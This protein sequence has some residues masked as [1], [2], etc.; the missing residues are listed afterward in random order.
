MK[1]MITAR[2]VPLLQDSVNH[3]FRATPPFSQ[4]IRRFTNNVSDMKKL[5]ARDYEDMLQVTSLP[6]HDPQQTHCR[7]ITPYHNHPHRH[8]AVMRPTPHCPASS[9]LALSPPLTLSSPLAPHL[10]ISLRHHLAVPSH[11]ISPCPIAVRCWPYPPPMD[12]CSIPVF[13]DLLDGH[14]NK[15]LIKLL[16]RTAEWHGFAKL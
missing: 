9:C 11:H 8:L 14:H 16:Y 2:Y 6:F 7:C 12:Q 5:A 13:E 3:R 4:T 1:G 15:R 10:A